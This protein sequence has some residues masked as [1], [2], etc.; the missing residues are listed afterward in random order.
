M[1]HAQWGLSEIL[2]LH[3]QYR[4]KSCTPGLMRTALHYLR[5][6]CRFPTGRERTGL[7]TGNL[8]A[9]ASTCY[10]FAIFPCI[11]V[12][13]ARQR[14]AQKMTAATSHRVQKGSF[15]AFRRM[16]EGLS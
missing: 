7:S 14:V 3:A 9:S 11:N 16:R 12:V 4:M 8:E 1:F 15:R 2:C 5:F 10:V 6:R 13:P